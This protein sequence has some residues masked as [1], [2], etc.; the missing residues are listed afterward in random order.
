[1]RL[2]EETSGLLRERGPFRGIGHG[3]SGVAEITMSECY[4]LPCTDRPLARSRRRQDTVIAVEGFLEP[5]N[6][7]TPHGPTS[8]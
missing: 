6:V 8:G 4:L 3:D 7:M 2:V 5:Q 1:M